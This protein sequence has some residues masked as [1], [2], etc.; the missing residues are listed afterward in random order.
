MKRSKLPVLLVFFMSGCILV[1]VAH[2]APVDVTPVAGREQVE[3]FTRLVNA[4]RRTVGCRPLTW[5]NAVARVAQQHSEDMYHYK[6]FDHINQDGR[7]PFERLTRARIRY[8]A[9]GE[10][11]A[12]GQWTAQQV[13]DSWLSSAGHRRNIENCAL[14]EHGV[15]LANNHWTHVL[16]TL[17]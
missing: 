13:L 12:A 6:F 2:Q 9:A 11:I 15:G 3:E 17:R 10:N 7:D 8:R 5:V 4:H 14:L 1:P 16:V